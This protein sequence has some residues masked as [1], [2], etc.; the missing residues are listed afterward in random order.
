LV[1]LFAFFLL[2]SAFEGAT[3]GEGSTVYLLSLLLHL[4][5]VIFVVAVLLLSWKHERMGGLLFILLSVFF[6]VISRLESELLLMMPGPLLLIGVLFILDSYL[7]KK[8]TH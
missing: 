5:P 7:E 3:A 8:I 4:V 1:L 6:L 2:L